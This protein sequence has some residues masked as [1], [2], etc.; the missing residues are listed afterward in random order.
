[1]EQ[2]HKCSVCGKG[3]AMDWARNNHEK[4]CKER[5]KSADKTGIENLK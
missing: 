1:M 4:L 3:Y 2:R 5:K